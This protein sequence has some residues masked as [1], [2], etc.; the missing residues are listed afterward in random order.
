MLYTAAFEAR[1]MRLPFWALNS[2]L[3]EESRREA[4]ALVQWYP[5]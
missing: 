3:G 2:E 4:L 1:D 5:K